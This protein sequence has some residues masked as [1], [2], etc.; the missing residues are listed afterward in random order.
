MTK[1]TPA[2][3]SILAKCEGEGHI[4]RPTNHTISALRERGLI[5]K[6]PRA[7]PSGNWWV[8]TDAGRAVLA[9][10]PAPRTTP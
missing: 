8:L 2:Q 5:E 9:T 4:A 6:T 3:R 10:S 7:S 1:L